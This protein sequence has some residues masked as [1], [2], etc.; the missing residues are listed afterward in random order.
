MTKLLFS[1]F[2]VGISILGHGQNTL[3][4]KGDEQMPNETTAVINP[5]NS[6][7]M[8]VGANL[9]LIC[10]SKDGGTTWDCNKITSD[11]GF[12]GDPVLLATD[13]LLYCFHLSDPDGKNWLAPSFLDRIVVQTSSDFGKTWSNGIGIGYNGTKDQDKPWA[14]YNKQTKEVYVAWTEFDEY[15]SANPDDHSRILFSKTKNGKTWSTPTIVSKKEGDC[16]D[17][18]NTTEGAIPFNTQAE[19]KVIWMYGKHAYINTSKDGIQ[20]PKKE[21]KILDRP[22][23]WEFMVPGFR[24]VNGLPSIASYRKW[25]TW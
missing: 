20:F 10:Y 23:G 6:L 16:L 4:Y 15:S 24:R 19:I 11:Y 17:D 2:L 22:S 7:E 5:N 3:I 25:C 14:W 12:Y 18:E 9:N 13:S 8:C 1:F 21:K